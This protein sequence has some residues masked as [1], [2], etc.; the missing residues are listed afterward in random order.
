MHN[1]VIIT[2]PTSNNL[3]VAV[4]NGIIP[5]DLSIDSFNAVPKVNMKKGDNPYEIAEDYQ[6]SSRTKT[7]E[8]KK[9]KLKSEKKKNVVDDEDY[10]KRE[11]Y[12]E[13]RSSRCRS[14]N[15]L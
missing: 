8:E 9:T 14:C 6:T 2:E 7:A 12:E 11:M 3:G 5:G 15:V 10:L 13:C 4:K 1:R